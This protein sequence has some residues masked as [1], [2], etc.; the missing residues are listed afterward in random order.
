MNEWDGNW[1]RELLE[2]VGEEVEVVWNGIGRWGGVF[3]FVVLDF[4]FF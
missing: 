4:F 1:Y 2:V 3:C